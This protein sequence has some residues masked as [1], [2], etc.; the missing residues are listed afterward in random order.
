MHMHILMDDKVLFQTA[1]TGA[2]LRTMTALE[3]AFS[4][5]DLLLV[6]FNRCPG[7]VSLWT[8]AA[9]EGSLVVIRRST[10]HILWLIAW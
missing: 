6:L 9:L 2:N 10:K 1:L 3:S 7:N 5:V 8:K 4:R